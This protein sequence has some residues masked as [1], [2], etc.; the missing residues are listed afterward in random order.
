MGE[1]PRVFFPIISPIQMVYWE[2]LG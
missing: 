1:G 2:S